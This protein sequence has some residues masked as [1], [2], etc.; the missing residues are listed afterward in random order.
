MS[1]AEVSDVV[2]VGPK[3]VLV[4]GKNQG[5]TDL[6]VWPANPVALPEVIVVRVE[7]NP[8]RSH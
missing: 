3:D 7:Q 1:N 4:L 5:M 6:T 8:S 2:Q